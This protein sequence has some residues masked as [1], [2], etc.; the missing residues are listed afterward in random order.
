ML[1]SPDASRLG[2]RRI[3]QTAR[4]RSVTRTS[5]EFL[6]PSVKEYDPAKVWEHAFGS[7]LP[8]EDARVETIELAFRPPW[9]TWFNTTRVHA[10][11][12]DPKDLP[13][14]EG[15][16]VTFRL[17][18]TLDFIRWVRGFGKAVKVLSPPG[19]LAAYDDPTKDWP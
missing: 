6:Y 18:V 5:T 3:F 8:D 1:D 15:F 12:S 11:Q 17:K 14:G 16:T 7:W 13:G 2:E 9:R 4:I 10:S 19:L